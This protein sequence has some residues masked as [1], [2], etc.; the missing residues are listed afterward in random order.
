M[1]G[2]VL[3]RVYINGARM[4]A[5]AGSIFFSSWICRKRPSAGCLHACIV[6]V[7]C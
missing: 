7:V 2:D 4:N 6:L 1:K 3:G 5:T